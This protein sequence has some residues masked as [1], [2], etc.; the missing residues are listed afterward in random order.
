[1]NVTRF[2]WKSIQRLSFDVRRTGEGSLRML[3]RTCTWVRKVA[4]EVLKKKKK[5][6]KPE[7]YVAKGSRKM[8]GYL[9]FELSRS[10]RT[11]LVSFLKS[12]LKVFADAGVCVWTCA[13]LCA[14]ISHRSN[15][16]EADH[17]RALK[18]ISVGS[19][20]V[21]LRSCTTT[22]FTFNSGIDRRLQC[23]KMCWPVFNSLLSGV[24][25]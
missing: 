23:C 14:V 13:R 5:S 7:E 11:L 4:N 6:R 9:Y 17:K 16:F 21:V 18:T 2:R 10:D 24:L 12:K 22:W 8:T 1:M 25:T 15:S 19:L 3:H 20:D